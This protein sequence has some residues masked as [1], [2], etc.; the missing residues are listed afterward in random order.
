MLT[1]K[2]E[3]VASG[4]SAPCWV[5]VVANHAYITNTKTNNVTA[6][7]VSTDGMISLLNADGVTGQTGAN[8]IDVDASDDGKVLYTLNGKATAACSPSPPTAASRRSPTCSVFR[9]PRSVSSRAESAHGAQFACNPNLALQMGATNPP[10]A[11]PRANPP[12]TT[13]NIPF[14]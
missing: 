5:T 14:T 10:T 12:N 3:K 6:Y 13:S 4:Q 7:N 11:R 1:P 8:P 9:K 2:S